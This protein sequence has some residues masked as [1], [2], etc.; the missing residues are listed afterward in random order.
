ML[1]LGESQELYRVIVMNGDGNNELVKALRGRRSIQFHLRTILIIVGI[2]CASFA[3][4]KKLLP[5]I[6][7]IAAHH[8][9]SCP[10]CHSTITVTFLRVG[11]GLYP[12]HTCNTCGWNH[13]FDEANVLHI[14]AY[15]AWMYHVCNVCGSTSLHIGRCDTLTEQC[16]QLTCKECGEVCHFGTEK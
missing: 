12:V 13:H 4:V 6:E 3:G 11:I 14:P 7:S 16:V 5:F 8:A 9:S 15:N 10:V 1:G 2:C